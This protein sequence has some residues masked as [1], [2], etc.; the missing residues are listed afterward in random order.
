[1]SPTAQEAID[2]KMVE[3]LDGTKNDY[4]FSKSKLGANA[5]LAVSL[6]VARAGAAAKGLPLYKYIA[7]L[8]G[9]KEYVMPVPAFN[10]INGGSH[11]GNQLAIQEFMILPTGAKDFAEGLKMGAEVY[12]C[13]KKVVKEK[14]GHSATN[15]GDEGGFAPDN[16]NKASDVIAWLAEAIKNAGYEG[17]IKLGM[18]V[19]A[20]EFYDAEKK[21]Y[22]LDKWVKKDNDKGEGEKSGEEM[23]KMYQEIAKQAA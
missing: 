14:G 13:L 15:V 20:S 16:I 19:A 1:M 3:E 7:E 9:N 2:M 11:A 6:A 17:K 12:Q 5:I 4:G 18:D 8:A 23:I 10:V 21:K 22:D